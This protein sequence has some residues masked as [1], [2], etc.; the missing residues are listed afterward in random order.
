MDETPSTRTAN[1][2]LADTITGALL[3]ADLVPAAV[4]AQLREKLAAGAA[5][6]SDWTAW[7]EAG[8]DGAAGEE[9]HGRAD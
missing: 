8:L 4:A 6:E 5:R 7:I 9:P 2:Q 1:D 3:A